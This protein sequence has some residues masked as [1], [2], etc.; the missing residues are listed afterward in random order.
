MDHPVEF[1]IRTHIHDARK[2]HHGKDSQAFA[3]F[4]PVELRGR[5]TDRSEDRVLTE[6]E[7]QTDWR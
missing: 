5:E 7:K 4:P 2:L 1:D 3:C 6:C